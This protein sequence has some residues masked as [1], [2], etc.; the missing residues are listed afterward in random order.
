MCTNDIQPVS[1]LLPEPATVPISQSHIVGEGDFLV[2][3]CIS[4]IDVVIHQHFLGPATF[5]DATQSTDAKE[6][7]SRVVEGLQV[8][9]DSLPTEPLVY[10]YCLRR[11]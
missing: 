8:Q 7:A 4:L 11:S 1:A 10:L 6:A 3:L 9:V 2:R 5:Q